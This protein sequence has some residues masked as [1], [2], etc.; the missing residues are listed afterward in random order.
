M[1]VEVVMVRPIHPG[2]IGSMCRV[3]K[4]FGL[5]NLTLIKTEPNLESRKMAMHAK[6]ILNNCKKLSDFRKIKAD[7][8]VGTTAVKVNE[9]NLRRNHIT[10]EKLA[11]LV[12]KRKG[13]VAIL[14]GPEDSGLSNKDLNSCDLVVSIS[15]NPGYPTLNITHAAAILFYEIF[16]KNKNES[17]DVV[18]REELDVLYETS[19]K[20]VKLLGIRRRH[21]FELLLRRIWGRGL[22]KRQVHGVIG[23]LKKSIRK[24]KG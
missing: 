11:E 13:K 3:M 20:W 12:S 5:N 2:N 22:T 10:P 1:N 16:R 15:S 18:P 19:D 9:Y 6:D 21:Q 17:E 4:N 23:L 8:L 14:F 7:L 24:M